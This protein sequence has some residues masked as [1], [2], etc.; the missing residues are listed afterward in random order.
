MGEQ[1]RQ[2]GQLASHKIN[3]DKD[4]HPSLDPLPQRGWS[5]IV[6]H[7]LIMRNGYSFQ[8]RFTKMRLRKETD[9]GLGSVEKLFKQLALLTCSQS[10]YIEAKDFEHCAR[11]EHCFHL[12]ISMAWFQITCQAYNAHAIAQQN[13]RV[14]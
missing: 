12:N 2:F 13:S 7:N 10:I 4:E 14:H 9:A 3:V 11:T 1:A 5:A 6:S 8:V